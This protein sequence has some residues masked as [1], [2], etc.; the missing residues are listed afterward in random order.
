MS[1]EVLTFTP[2]FGLKEDIEYSTLI[3]ESDSGKEKRRSKRSQAIRTLDCFLESESEEAI[4]LIWNFFKARKG[5]YDT[6]WVKFPT[7]YKVENEAVGI[8]NDIDT[9]FNLDLFPIDTASIKVYL[10]GLQVRPDYYN[11]RP[12]ERNREDRVRRSSDAG[13]AITADYEYYVQA[14]FEEDK[15]SRELVSVKLYNSSIKLKEV[16]WNIYEGALMQDLSVQFKEEALKTENRP[17]ELYDFYLGSQGSCDGET[18][19]FTSDNRR[20]TSGILT[21]R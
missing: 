10:N 18:Y 13:V 11:E 14:R 16:L 21:G 6:F 7:N 8:G 4:D 15:L 1:T 19:Y 2:A 5:R 12:D 9:V 3:F 17:I 20:R